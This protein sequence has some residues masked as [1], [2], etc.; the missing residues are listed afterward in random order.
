MTSENQTK[1]KE[2][3]CP[4]PADGLDG[5]CAY[6]RATFSVD[7]E[8]EQSAENV[9]AEVQLRRN[10]G[11]HFNGGRRLQLGI[12]EADAAI[13]YK[14]ITLDKGGLYSREVAAERN[15][16][17][18]VVARFN[19]V[20][21]VHIDKVQS[22]ECVSC[23]RPLARFE[24][25]LRC[26][27]CLWLIRLNRSGQLYYSSEVANMIGVSHE[28]ISNWLRAGWI[29][30]QDRPKGKRCWTNADVRSLTRYKRKWYLRRRRKL[31]RRVIAT[32]RRQRTRRKYWSRRSQGLCGECGK[33]V[34]PAGLSL[35][36]AC[37]AKRSVEG[38][39]K[40]R[41][42]R[43]KNPG[44]C[45]ACWKRPVLTRRSECFE[46]LKKMRRRG[47]LRY[48]RRKRKGLCI[49]CG[50]NRRMLGR[51]MCSP[52]Y[53]KQATSQRN[54]RNELRKAGLCISCAK[55]SRSTKAICNDCQRRIRGREKNSAA[56]PRERINRRK[57]DE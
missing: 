33:K 43:L 26:Q 29:S 20:K 23:G 35:C 53:E 47:R 55:P 7:D 14:E 42:R 10:N 56:Q 1:C 6:H 52:C 27:Y 3:A 4:F 48:R 17:R 9:F 16:F 57:E 13:L 50:R 36:D 8:E 41:G 2:K 34:G 11:Y 21:E 32:L 45:Q 39:V 25:R 38:K 30:F 40:R 44:L 5:L 54:R 31:S 24:R 51:P 49:N 18:D 19:A 12:A 22:R 46:C 15:K 28:T 37:R